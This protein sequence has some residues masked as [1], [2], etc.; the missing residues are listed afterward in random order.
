MDAAVQ[1]AAD[2]LPA[3]TRDIARAKADLERHG[4]CIVRDVLTAG[5]VAAL[6]ARVG[7]QARG[8][9]AAGKGFHDGGANQ[10]IWMLLNKGRVFRDLVLHPFA[11]EMMTPLLG[12]D[13]LLSSITANVARPGGEPMYLHTDQGY[14]DFWTEL[15]LVANIAWMLDDFSEENGGTRL[16]PGSHRS[17]EWRKE[18]RRPTVAAAGPA[19]SALVFDGRLI[20][21]TGA[22]RTADQ[23]RHA[24]LTYYCRPFM[25]Q[26][27]N[28]FLGLDPALRSPENE[29]L[30]RRLGFSIWRGLGRI[31]TPLEGRLMAG[32]P[33]RVPALDAAGR[34]CKADTP[35]GL[36]PDEPQQEA[37]Q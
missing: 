16:A 9:D 22:N 14:V 2:E 20:H 10:R 15:P 17:R 35:L 24:I 34:P 21:G 27:E 25:R 3:P 18:L 29:P 36:T 6:R 30:L 8:E 28:F 31:E 11:V 37:P 13:F 4:Y 19:G 1:T 5:Q 23:Q 32:E 12:P 26:Q 33:A 7:A